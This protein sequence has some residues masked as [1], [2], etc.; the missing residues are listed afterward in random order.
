MFGLGIRREG[1]RIT[2]ARALTAAL[3]CFSLS[4]C[5]ALILFGAGTAAGVTG[6]KYYE[7]TLTVV[8]QAPYMETWDATLAAL[9]DLKLKVESSDHDLT[10]GKIT[11]RRSDGKAVTVSLEYKSARETEAVIRVGIFGD[12]AASIAIKEKIRE[13]ILQR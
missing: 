2:M 13:K 4:G 1:L 3:L 11:A 12:E 9:E 6:Y 7:G 5:G 8:F 10:S